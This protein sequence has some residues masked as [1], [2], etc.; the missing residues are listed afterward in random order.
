MEEDRRDGQLGHSESLLDTGFG[1]T[2]STD[3]ST[4]VS[5]GVKVKTEGVQEILTVMFSYVS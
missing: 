5:I 4:W 3:E 1:S 2:S